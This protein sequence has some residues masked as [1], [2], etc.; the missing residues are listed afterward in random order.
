[1][2]NLIIKNAEQVVTCSG[3]AGKQGREMSDLHVIENGTVIVTD[4]L[5]SHI[6]KAGETLPVNEQDYRVI[7]ATGKALLPGFI[8]PHTHFIFGGYRE[9]EF[10]WR[11]RGDSYMEIM[12]RGGGIVK[13]TNATREATEEELM[14]TGRQRLDAMMRLGITTVEGK[15]GYGLDKDTELKQLRVMHR[16]N[17]THPVDIVSTFMGAHAIPAEWQGREEDYIDFNIN[18]MFPLVVKGELAEAVDIFCEKGVFAIAQSRRYL[19]AARE[20]GLKIKIHADEITPLGGA[21]L[22][23]ELRCLSADHLLQASDEGIRAMAEKGVVA[24]LLPLTAF[25][26]RE[27]YARAREMIDA[28]CIV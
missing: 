3:F 4:G 13:T 8:D 2:N 20:Q 24:T 10:S 21:E 15:S 11:M 9:E 16:L 22:A 25:S 28:G 7:D 1:M 14:E 19:T 17:E 6:L 18:E 26:L 23:A 5:I 27:K 12:E